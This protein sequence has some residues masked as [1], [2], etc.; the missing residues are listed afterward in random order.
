MDTQPDKLFFARLAD[1]VSRCGRDC[2]PVFSSFFD[3][4]QCAEAELWCRANVGSLGYLMWGGYDGARRKMLAV[5][6][7]Y[8][9]DGIRELFPMKC[10]TFIFREEDKLTHRDFLGSFMAQM[11]KREVIGDIV[12]ED[13]L[14]QTFVTDIAAETIMSSV[15]KIGRVGVKITDSRPF[16][17]TD[18][19]KFQDM[20]GTVASLR[21]DCVVSLAAKVSREKAAELIRTDRVDVNHITADSCSKELAEG[22]I[23]SV[24]GCGRFI[25]SGIGGETKKRRIHIILKKFI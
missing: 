18:A 5:Y 21:L 10:L 8:L 14:A 19:Q 3:E 7:D 9:E 1:M 2:A 20:G 25:L 13:G 16:E 11:L 15:T 22:D 23:L 17:L 4:R 6:P 24:R 12:A